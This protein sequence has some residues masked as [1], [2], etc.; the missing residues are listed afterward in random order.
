MIALLLRRNSRRCAL[1]FLCATSC[2]LSLATIACDSKENYAFIASRYDTVNNCKEP[3]RGIDVR[4]GERRTCPI[5]CIEQGPDGGIDFYTTTEC[6]PDDP[7]FREGDPVT[8]A[9]ALKATPCG[10]DAGRD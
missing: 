7:P 5:R 2:F 3:N 1:L 10:V 9:R 8:C 4:E 6:P